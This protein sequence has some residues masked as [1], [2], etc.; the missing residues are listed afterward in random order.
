MRR[1]LGYLPLVAMALLVQLIAPIGAVRAVAQAISDPLSLSAICSGLHDSDQPSA[2]AGPAEP[3]SKCCGFC[4]AAQ[5][6]GAALNPPAPSFVALQRQYQ[7]VLWLQATP[8]PT[9]L[10]A[11]SNAQARAPPLF[12]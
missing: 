11:G 7:R 2:P 4:A 5:A 12:S 9:P 3:D 8:A 6:G 10:R 1:R